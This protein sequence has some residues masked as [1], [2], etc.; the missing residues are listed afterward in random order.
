MPG[1]PWG[2][3]AL[4]SAFV[5]WTVM[6]AIMMLPSAL[7]MVRAVA[8]SNRRAVAAGAAE[9]PST[10]FVL[11]YLLAWA[12]FSALATTLQALLRSLALLTSALSVSNPRLGG[13]ILVLAGAWQFTPLKSGCLTRCRSPL[14]FLLMHWRDGTR[15]A[16]VMGVRHGLFCVGCCWALMLVLFVVGVMNLWW[17][18]AIAAVIALEKL[19]LGGQWLPRIMGVGLMLWGALLLAARPIGP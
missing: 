18:A 6:M 12:G 14:S 13:A 3:G 1:S 10:V 9:T 5:M 8:A 2:A 19:A 16:L 11:G 4:G 17:V 7:P 15:G